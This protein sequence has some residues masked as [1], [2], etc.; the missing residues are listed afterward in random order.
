MTNPRCP[1]EDPDFT[2]L[3]FRGK[4]YHMAH[5]F[6]KDRPHRSLCGKERREDAY[7]AELNE[8]DRNMGVLGYACGMCWPLWW[9]LRRKK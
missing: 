7:P 4:R 5:V 6:P 1:T 3:R 8:L 9:K 2:V